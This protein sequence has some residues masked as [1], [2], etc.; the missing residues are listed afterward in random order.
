MRVFRYCVLAV[1]LLSAA[2]SFA[3]KEDW[4]PITQQDLQIKEVPGAPGAPAIQ[5]YYADFID[6]VHHSEYLHHRIKILNEKG[7][8]YAD[9]ELV[10]P[11]NFSITD[12]KART[13]HPDG[14]IIEF[15]G[16]AFEKTVIKGKGIK[17][18]ARTF[19]LPDVTVGSMIEYRYRWIPPENSFLTNEWIVQHDLYTV[20]EY[21][22]MKPYQ[23]LMTSSSGEGPA[24]ISV[25]YKLPG[26]LLPKVKGDEYQMEAENIPA[27]EEEEYMPPAET[28]KPHVRFFYELKKPDSIDKFWADL[29]KGLYNRVQHFTGNSN[30]VKQAAK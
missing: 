22:R 23:G 16:K 24:Q 26:N 18:L 20:K 19:T 14:K 1:C 17:I 7:I 10:P 11:L 13:I 3:Q 12:L 5:L 27:F 21:F 2:Y 30:E 25:V 8:K 6:D 15:S 28:Y 29:G 9:V 4:L